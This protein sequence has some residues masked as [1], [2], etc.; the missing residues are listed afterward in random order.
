[1]SP[2]LSSICRLKNYVAAFYKKSK[3]V[4]K[5]NGS[6]AYVCFYQQAFFV[7]DCK[8]C[9]FIMSCVS[10]KLR[11]SDFA[12]NLAVN[13]KNNVRFHGV[14]L[15]RFIKYSTVRLGFIYN[16]CGILLITANSHTCTSNT[17]YLSY[18]CIQ[19]SR[20]KLLDTSCSYY[21]CWSDSRELNPRFTSY[22][23]IEHDQFWTFK[24][25]FTN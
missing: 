14:Y 19:S 20:K 21:L 24:D 16:L 3:T 9:L 15:M 6:K 11:R 17:A 18:W 2:G 13:L 7:C 1:M 4:F 10:T 12:S 23:Q 22:E 8:K 5:C 25:Q